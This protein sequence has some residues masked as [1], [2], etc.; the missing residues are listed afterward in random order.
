MRNVICILLVALALS[1][2][3]KVWAAEFT[4]N[5]SVMRQED[6]TTWGELWYNKKVIWRLIFLADGARP[7]AA[8]HNEGTTLIAPDIINGSFLIKVQ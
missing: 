4:L 7:V 1:F 3:N 2:P 8:Y 6:G 5:I